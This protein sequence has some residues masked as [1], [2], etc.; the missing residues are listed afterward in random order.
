MRIFGTPFGTQLGML[1]FDIECKELARRGMRLYPYDRRYTLRK[2]IRY[3]NVVGGS[4]DIHRPYMISRQ[5]VPLNI[6]CILHL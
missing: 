2:R 6:H 1:H 4:I 5:H 3:E